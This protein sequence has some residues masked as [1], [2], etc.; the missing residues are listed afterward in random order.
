MNGDS[1][2]RSELCWGV[3]G[4]ERVRG[5]KRDGVKTEGLEE[6]LVGKR[7]V[8]LSVLLIPRVFVSLEQAHP[9]GIL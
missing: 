5:G 3:E 2:P 6:R 9:A 8:R 7:R 4:N 1:P